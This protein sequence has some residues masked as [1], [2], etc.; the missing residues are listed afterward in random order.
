MDLVKSPNSQYSEVLR[1]RHVKHIIAN[2][3]YEI[4]TTVFR[5]LEINSEQGRTRVNPIYVWTNPAFED[6]ARAAPFL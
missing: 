6:L 4:L 1:L 5:F 3:S 2:F